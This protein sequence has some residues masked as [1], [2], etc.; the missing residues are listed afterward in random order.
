MRKKVLFLAFLAFAF[1]PATQS[2]DYTCQ[3]LIEE[4]YQCVGCEQDDLDYIF[5]DLMEGGCIMPFWY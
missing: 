3:E 1:I 2:Q 5:W 4:W